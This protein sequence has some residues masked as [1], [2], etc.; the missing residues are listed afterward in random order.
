MSVVVIGTD[1]GKGATT[2]TGYYVQS[3]GDGDVEFNSQDIRDETNQL[4]IRIVFQRMAKLTL[5]LIPTLKTDL[6]TT[7]T[8]VKTDFPK[9]AMSTAT[10]LTAFFV[11][12]CQINET[13][14]AIQVTVSMTNI[15][16]TVA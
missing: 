5:T 15:G 13:G 11:D 14:E 12:D 10:G 16:I 2:V 4:V 9:G 6:A 3:Y 1:V 8:S 7:V